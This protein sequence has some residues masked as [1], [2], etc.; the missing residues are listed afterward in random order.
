[1]AP[2][3]ADAARVSEPSAGVYVGNAAA[4]ARR[5]C[6]ASVA[7]SWN[8]PF[9]IPWPRALASSANETINGA[10]ASLMLR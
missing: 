6:P 2:V 4:N 9:D 7:K 3:A 1:M 10:T 8:T 5:Y